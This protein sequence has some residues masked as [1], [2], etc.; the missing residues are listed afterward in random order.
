MKLNMGQDG[1][2]WIIHPPPQT[3]DA[4][5]THVGDYDI[6]PNP[7]TCKRTVQRIEVSCPT[8]MPGCVLQ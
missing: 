1:D 8:W 4:N 3:S 6:A 7:N 2:D 5:T